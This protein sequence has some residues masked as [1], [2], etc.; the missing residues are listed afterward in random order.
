MANNARH[1]IRF[2]RC[3]YCRDTCYQVWW[4]ANY[5]RW[6][7]ATVVRSLRNYGVGFV[8]IVYDEE[9]AYKETRNLLMATLTK[10]S[11]KVRIFKPASFC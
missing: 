7:T 1:T 5:D 6:Y 11:K 8:E 2:K 3:D 9:G 10:D 4:G